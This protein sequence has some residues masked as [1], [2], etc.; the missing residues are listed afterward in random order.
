MDWGWRGGM[1]GRDGGGGTNGGEKDLWRGR[2]WYWASWSFIVA[3]LS[4][5]VSSFLLCP[6]HVPLLTCPHCCV[7]FAWVVC[8]FI[9]SVSRWW[10]FL[11][12][13][14]AVSVWASV[15]I[16]L[17]CCS[18]FGW[19]SSFVGGH[20]HCMGACG[21]QQWWVVIGVGHLTAGCCG[22]CCP[23]AVVLCHCL[24]I[25]WCVRL[26]WLG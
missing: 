24:V 11:C 14:V 12:M 1:E 22:S 20:F 16:I 13:V 26:D 2:E 5:F 10:R 6:P 21:S 9:V 25:C 4:C 17:G 15:R 19:S 18:L 3:S 8:H 7:V 23:V